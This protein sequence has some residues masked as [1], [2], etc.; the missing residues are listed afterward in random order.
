MKLKFLPP[1]GGAPISDG[2]RWMI[3]LIANTVFFVALYYLIPL[4]G[5]IY[6]PF[7]YLAVGIGVGLWY[8]LYN[9]GFNTRGKTPEML[10][11]EI[12]L[13]ER[14]AMIAEGR[15]RLKKSRWALTVI[16]PVIITFFIDMIF[17]FLIP[18]GLF[19]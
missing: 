8:V 11:D 19:S 6:L 14:E 15:Q 3:I 9:R 18:E 5:F 4:L 12:P 16:L 10:S 7:I 2:R 17:L 1:F 13:A